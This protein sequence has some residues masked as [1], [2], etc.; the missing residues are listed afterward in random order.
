LIDGDSASRH[1][2]FHWIIASYNQHLLAVPIALYQALFATIGLTHYWVFRL[3]L[4]LAHVACVAAVF[5][6]ARRRIGWAWWLAYHQPSMARQNL[7]AVPAY[8]ADLAASAI[9]GL[10]GLNIDWGRA[11]LVAGILVLGRRLVRPGL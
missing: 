1:S 2:G 4:A 7:T 5:A 11:L 10:L 6:Y 3:F 8:S 9:G